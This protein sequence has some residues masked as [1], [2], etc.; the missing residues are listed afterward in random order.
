MSGRTPRYFALADHVKRVSKR[1]FDVSDFFFYAIADG[2]RTLF[3]RH[4]RWNVLDGPDKET[5]E[6]CQMILAL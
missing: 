1:M 4:G 3:S 2:L 6:P 5:E